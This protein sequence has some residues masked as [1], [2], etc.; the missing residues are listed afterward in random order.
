MTSKD[1]P[2]LA[3]QMSSPVGSPSVVDPSKYVCEEDRKFLDIL[4]RQLLIATLFSTTGGIALG[5]KFCKRAAL[6][7]A[8][9]AAVFGAAGLGTPV[10]C[11]GAL[12]KYHRYRHKE[13]F[14]RVEESMHRLS[15]D[16]YEE[17]QRTGASPEMMNFE[18]INQVSKVIPPPPSYFTNSM[19]NDDAEEA[20]ASA[21]FNQPAFSTTIPNPVA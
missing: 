18:R 11:L 3:F 15:N 10:L 8:S 4:G 9:K 13:V 16:M 19:G 5:S 6:Q 1:T 7:G 14:D 20:L 12:Y 2:E 21:N 17:R